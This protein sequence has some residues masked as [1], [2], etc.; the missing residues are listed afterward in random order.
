M[1]KNEP[2][3]QITPV[4]TKPA[5]NMENE[6]TAVLGP[7]EWEYNG[8]RFELDLQDVDVAERY[9]TCFD[10]M[11]KAEKAVPKTGNNSTILRHYI[12]MFKDLFDGLLGD[13][14]YDKITGGKNNV[15]LCMA[16]YDNLLQ[17][18]G[19]QKEASDAQSK[20]YIDRYSNR[21]QRRAAARGKQ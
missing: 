14:A 9:E 2:V 11:E 21:A 6:E 19:R 18:I 10:K 1:S 7:T 8:Y 20:A 5:D 13:G 16:A 15:R 12:T 3:R 4:E 17:F